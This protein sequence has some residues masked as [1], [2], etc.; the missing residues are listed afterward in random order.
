MNAVQSSNA[1]KLRRAV[2][3]VQGAV[4]ARSIG[5]SRSGPIVPLSHA[6]ALAQN[7]FTV[8]RGVIP[9]AECAE[10]AARFKAAAGIVEGEHFTRTDATNKIPVTREILFDKRILAAVH[11]AMGDDV[12]FLQTSDLHYLHDTAGWHR[13]SVHRAHDNSTSADWSDRDG[14]YG[15]VKAI[16]YLESDN[17]AMGIMAGSHLSPIEIDADRVRAVE[18]RGGH[19]VIDVD[20][21]PNRR[22]SAEQQRIPLAWRAMPGDVLVFDQRMYHAGRRVDDGKVTKDRDAAKFT[23]SLVFGIDNMHSERFYSYFRYA[24]RELGFRTIQP[25]YLEEL[26][27]HGL[28]LSNGYGNYYEQHPEELRLASLRKPETMD[29]LV[30]QFAADGRAKA[31]K[32]ESVQR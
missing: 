22:L 5:A 21:E 9:E 26:R 8:F 1:Q 29:A 15:I 6:D 19:L 30:A 27:Q 10:V 25:D 32:E 4:R 31:A 7:G 20:D 3:L 17:A 14:R 12:C 23:L 2:K 16:L 18:R 13:D 11:E 24:R 28:L